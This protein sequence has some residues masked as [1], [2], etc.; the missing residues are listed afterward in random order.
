MQCVSKAF[1]HYLSFK[2]TLTL[3]F[4]LDV[5]VL[6]LLKR[7]LIM[8]ITGKVQLFLDDA[9]NTSLMAIAIF[10][11]W[12]IL[13]LFKPTCKEC[14]S[15]K[16]INQAKLCNSSRPQCSDN[17]T[18]TVKWLILNTLFVWNLQY[19]YLCQIFWLQIASV[20]NP[21]TAFCAD[22]AV[23][24]S[25]HLEPLTSSTYNTKEQEWQAFHY[26]PVIVPEGEINYKNTTNSKDNSSVLYC[27]GTS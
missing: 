3:G 25:D 8:Q 13:F 1:K 14:S 21:L 9:V 5:R 22:H 2:S 17:I 11:N 16:I 26:C 7:L 4:T 23:R 6:F 15:A 10:C 19:L 18:A 12:D 20:L 24:S 27:G